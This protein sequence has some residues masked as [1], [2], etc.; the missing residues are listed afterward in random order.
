[1]KNLAGLMKQAGQMQQKMQEMQERL[2]GMV[3]EGSSGAGMVTVSLTGKGEMRGVRIDPK[4]VDPPDIEM[5]QD[6]IV[7]AHADARRKVETAAARG[8]A[9]SCRRHEPAR[10]HET[11]VLS[12][13]GACHGWPGDRASHRIAGQTARAWPAQRQACHVAPAPRAADPHAAT[14]RGH[15]GGGTGGAKLFAVRQS[16]QH[17]P[18]HHLRRPAAGPQPVVRGRR[19]GRS[20]GAGALR[21]AS[22][23]VPRAG[24]D[25][26]RWPAAVRTT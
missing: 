20:V 3:L 1:M 9:E 5:L 22:R 13:L 15:A 24:R 18:V 8:D 21:R 23:P 25:A 11:A 26:R 16:G 7:A 14:R 2:D 17:R 12:F 4:L 10:R 6:L 19:R